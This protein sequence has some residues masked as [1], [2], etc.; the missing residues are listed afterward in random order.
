MVR[1]LAILFLRFPLATNNECIGSD[2]VDAR[3][4]GIDVPRWRV[5]VTR[6]EASMNEAN[7]IGL[8]LAKEVFQAHGASGWP[9]RLSEAIAPDE[10]PAIFCSP[11]AV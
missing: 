8:D 3:R 5:E 4:D 6:T 11:S 2:G 7:T 1:N 9:R 10:Y